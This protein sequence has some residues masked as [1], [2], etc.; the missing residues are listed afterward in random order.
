MSVAHDA[1]TRWPTTDVTGVDAT[2]GTRSF[3][4][5]PSG[6]PAGVVVVVWHQAT[7]A[8]CSGVTYGGVAMNLIQDATDTSES[9]RVQVY[10]LTN[11]AIPT[12]AQTVALS[13]CTGN[14]KF[15]TCTT[16]TASTAQTVTVGSNKK[17]TTTSSNP[18]LTVV[19][20][21]ESVLVGGIATGHSDATAL[22]AGSGYTTLAT[23][24]TGGQG[25]R[26]QRRTSA[27]AAGSI[28]FNWT[29]ALSEDH[30]IAAVAIGEKGQ[31][32]LPFITSVTQL[33][34][35][36]LQG[37]LS[38]PFIASATVLYTPTLQGR[39]EVPFIASATV[40]YTPTLQ[41]AGVNVPFI[42]SATVLHSPT[43][44]NLTEPEGIGPGNGGEQWLLRLAANGDSET[45]TLASNI[46]VS[47][48][49]SV[50]L[51]GDSGLPVAGT[52][53]LQ[54]DDEVIAVRKT[55][56]GTY[57]IARRGLSNTTPAAHFIGASAVWDDS[58]LMAIEASIGMTAETE[59]SSET[60]L[61]WLVVFDSSQ[62]YIGSDRYP[63]HVTELVGVFPAGDGVVGSLL[64]GSQPSAVHTPTGLSDDAP[65]ALTVPARLE[66]D[67]TAG[68]VAVVRYTNPDASVMTLGPR[69]VNVQGWYGFGRRDAS[70]NDVTLTDPNGTVVDGTA[71]DEFFETSFVTVT[72]PGDDRTYTYG[73][74]RYSNEGWP[75]AA[76]SVRHGTRRVPLWTSETWHNF[77]YVY[78][79]FHADAVYVQ[80]LVNRNGFH[81]PPLGEVALPHPDDID[82][83]D[84]TWDA[85]TGYYTSTSWYVGIFDTIFALGPS[86]NPPPGV[87][88]TPTDSPITIVPG[89]PP[90]FPPGDPEPPA[91]DWEGGSGGDISPPVGQ[92][93]HLHTDLGETGAFLNPTI[94]LA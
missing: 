7:T 20:S 79:G 23:V 6:T 35:P 25:G 67:I 1:T 37:K 64:D 36:T 33:Y 82:G 39:L 15:A 5:T 81:A 30:C 86:L 44:V 76:L 19:T 51:T 49:G 27:V 83:P 34:T 10:E 91:P 21:Q 26:F 14:N 94:S 69:A 57:G 24:D 66:S 85:T 16:L 13:G 11:Q 55:G 48:G 12:G 3:T 29:V 38:I 47:T 22:T 78:T 9:M 72:L 17:D 89:V 84:A 92:G 65:A 43:L 28:T 32:Q 87:P 90:G 2:T 60:L 93:V 46:G 68:D 54:I 63:M 77:D 80:V 31:V 62:A 8:P 50:S 53:L 74:P 70:N 4:H 71:H 18:T 42:P 56:S 88:P 61:G 59:V 58:Y 40:L 41:T 75:I 73:P 45:A 52:F